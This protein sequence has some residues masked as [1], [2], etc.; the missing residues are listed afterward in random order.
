M[1]YLDRKK[2]SMNKSQNKYAAELLCHYMS[3]LSEDYFCAGWLCGLEF[4]LWGM[5][6]AKADR[7]FGFGELNQEEI[8]KLVD[9][10]VA[11][12]GW[13]WWVDREDP[14]E[15]GEEFVT[16]DEWEVILAEAGEPPVPVK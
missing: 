15:S 14:V 1:T 10:S 2:A 16:W 11:A 4:T 9:L 13:W 6:F 5:A 8:D 12:G 3:D 7:T